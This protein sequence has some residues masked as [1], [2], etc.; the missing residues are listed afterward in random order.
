VLAQKQQLLVRYYLWTA[1]GP[2]RLPSQLH[3]DLM[4]RK[5]A[6]PQYAGTKQKVLEVLARRVG[7]DTYSLRGQG[8]IVAFDEDGYLKRTPAEEVMGFIV[9]RARQKLEDSSNVVSIEPRLRARRFKK[10]YSWQP[11]RSMLHLVRNDFTRGARRLRVL[12]RPS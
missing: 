10:E 9:E 3:Y 11:T 8:T 4:D 5:V 6:L 2:W 12:K 1:D 7:A